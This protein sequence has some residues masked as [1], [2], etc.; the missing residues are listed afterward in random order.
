MFGL[1]L[2][3]AHFSLFTFRVKDFKGWE[4]T[5][6]WVK[7]P[8]QVPQTN[9]LVVIVNSSNETLKVF[10]GKD[11]IILTEFSLDQIC[12]CGGGLVFNGERRLPRLAGC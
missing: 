6:E 8:E 11:W 4:F 10:G 3:Y 5:T 9:S 1:V 12:G 2:S 7:Y